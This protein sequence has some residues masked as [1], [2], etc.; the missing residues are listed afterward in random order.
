MWR[1]KRQENNNNST[2]AATVLE[3]AT[4]GG[5]S[6]SFAFSFT[7]LSDKV[8]EVAEVSEQAMRFAS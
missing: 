2:A 3:Q 8:A 6:N 1:E 5:G 4:Q 7:A